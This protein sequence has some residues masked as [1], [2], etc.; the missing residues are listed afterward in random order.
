MAR[1]REIKIGERPKVIFQE[2]KE[3]KK[4]FHPLILKLEI[5]EG[6]IT[7]FLND[8]RKVSIPI[9]WLVK[10]GK[11][12]Q[13]VVNADKL[14]NY[15]LDKRGDYWVYFPEVDIDLGVE[16]FTEGLKGICPNC[17]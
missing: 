3:T 15:E 7:A 1:L 13:K 11:R 17:H 5:S 16:V 10:W 2:Q 8:G 6:E 14:K 9:D 4:C 12:S